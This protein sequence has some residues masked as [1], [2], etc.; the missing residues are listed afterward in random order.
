MITL[1]QLLLMLTL[2]AP[3]WAQEEAW[4][5]DWNQTLAAAKK[6]GKVVVM[7]SA[8]PVVRKELPAKF[9]ARYGIALEYLGGRGADNSQ[10]LRM[11][12]QAGTYLVDAVFA[13][14]TNL[15]AELYVEKMLDPL[16]PLLILPEVVDPSKWKKGKIWFMDPEEKYIL[17]LYSYITAAGLYV[18][19]Q[20]VKPEEFKSIKELLNPKWRG[21][22]AVYDPTV[23]GTGSMDAARYYTEFGEDFVRKLYVDQKPAISRNKR[24][25]ADWLGR[26]VYPISLGVE[27]EAVITMKEQGLPVE[28]RAVPDAPSTLSAG[29]GL[30]GAMNRAPHP[31]AAK[32]FVNWIASKEGLEL[33]AKARNKP[34]TRTDIDESYALAWEIPQPGINYFDTYNWEFQFKVLPKVTEKMTEILKR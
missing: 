22:I 23:S 28:V 29:N 32:I 16:K 9:Q 26:G 10:K 25:L 4:K 18:N 12:R 15:G 2:A 19:T 24:Q 21:K 17:R 5:K 1:F 3:A 14:L 33:L 30:L 27:T 7:G 13:G 6:E 31:N 20:Q 34:Q 8:D 11:E